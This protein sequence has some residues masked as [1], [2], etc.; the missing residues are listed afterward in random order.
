MR[1]VGILVFDDVEIDTF[2]DATALFSATDDP[3]GSPPMFR[4]LL[5]AQ[6]M[7]AITCEGGFQLQPQATVRDHPSLDILLVPGGRGGGGGWPQSRIVDLL[8]VLVTPEGKGIRRERYNTTLLNW[9]REQSLRVETIVGIC[10][11]TV[12]LA[13]CGLLTGSR[14][15]THASLVPWMRM[16]YP[17]V[18]FTP[19]D[20]LVDTGQVLTATGWKGAFEASLHVIGKTCGASTALATALRVDPR[21]RWLASVGGAAAFVQKLTGIND[22]VLQYT[23]PRLEME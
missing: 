9:I 13:E 11:G 3:V 19:D 18:F 1:T 5:V 16:H 21:G 17:Q 7:R 15:T 6:T 20:R 4:S 8:E 10:S 22:R 14:A 2:A 12:L 23:K